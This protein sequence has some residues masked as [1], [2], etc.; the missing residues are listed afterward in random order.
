VCKSNAQ[1]VIAA[2]LVS[3]ALAHAT[4]AETVRA[5]RIA[6]DA[7]KAAPMFSLLDSAGKP[8]HLS[9][10]RG[11]IV[12]LNFWATECG[13]CR[14]EI[15]SLIE[16]DKAYQQK[17]VV[18]LAISMDVLYESLKDASQGWSRVKPFVQ[19]HR[20]GYRILMA[21]EEVIRNYD[22]KALPITYLID[23]KGRIAATY[24][25][26]LEEGDVEANLNVLLREH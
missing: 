7:R 18:V 26:V 14:L 3:I 23:A 24:A 10:F 6:P 5:S 9:N 25:G 17:G 8:V 12:I 19:E 22:V 16:V 2:L 11:K 15:P 20:V 1:R 21:D 4:R 13:G